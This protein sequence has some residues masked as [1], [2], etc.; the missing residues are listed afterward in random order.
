MLGMFSIFPFLK[1]WE[2]NIRLLEYTPTINRETS[3]EVK[4]F[5]WLLEVDIATNDAFGEVELN[6]KGASKS[7]I[8]SKTTV[9]PQYLYAGGVTGAFGMNSLTRYTRPSPTSTAG[10]Y[11]LRLYTGFGYGA[12]LPFL[13]KSL[14]KTRL[15]PGS[16]QTSC[17]ISVGLVTIDVINTELF[18]QS[19]RAV[20]GNRNMHVDKGLL[21]YASQF[22]EGQ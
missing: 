20:E 6:F 10:I 3:Y 2:W 1:G 11:V 12:T 16:T 17:T 9:F 21:E 22:F 19:I 14:V 15:L 5:G 13:D 8:I 4:G 7:G 18:I